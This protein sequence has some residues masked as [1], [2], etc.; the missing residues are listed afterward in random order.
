[1]PKT[2]FLLT[3]ET[4]ILLELARSASYGYEISKRVAKRLG[5]PVPCGTLYPALAKLEKAGWTT[6]AFESRTGIRHCGPPRRYYAITERGRVEAEA[7][8]ATLRR[9]A[10][11]SIVT[12]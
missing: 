4:M 2:T 11:P 10:L 1:M 12:T 5:H 6:G 7:I 9:L 8:S 3:A